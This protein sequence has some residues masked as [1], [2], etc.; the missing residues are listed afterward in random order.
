M[1]TPTPKPKPAEQAT[2]EQPAVEAPVDEDAAPVEEQPVLVEAPAWPPAA[3]P[4][5]LLP[6]DAPAPSGEAQVYG[7]AIPGAYPPGVPMPLPAG[8]SVEDAEA[9]IAANHLPLVVV[10][11][12]A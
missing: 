6:D 10:K 12:D 9:A 3:E 4:M 1:P 5:L 2:V 11:G 8:W 7:A